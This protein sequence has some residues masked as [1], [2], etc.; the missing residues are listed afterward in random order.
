[1]SRK[2]ALTLFGAT[3]FTGRLAA[4]YLASGRAKQAKISF[5]I[6]GRDAA[7]LNKLKKELEDKYPATAGEIGVLIASSENG[8]QLDAL[9]KATKVVVT[10]AGPYALY[11]EPLLKA[12]ITAGTDYLDLTGETPWSAMMISKYEELAK[13]TGSTCVSMSGFDSVPADLGVF[14]AADAARTR[15]GLGIK[16]A[17]SFMSGTG[18]VSGGTI[19]S[20][21][22]IAKNPAMNAMVKDPLLLFPSAEVAEAG[23]GSASSLVKAVPDVRLPFYVPEFDSTGESPSFLS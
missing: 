22:N 12:C 9:A 13:S 6:A 8:A 15:L 10:T 11:G 7:K 14:F 18:T 4:D 2:Y 17:T 3:G 23:T 1:M 19:A 20:G 5:A 21:I 16:E